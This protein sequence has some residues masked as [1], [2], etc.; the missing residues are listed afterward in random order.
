MLIYFCL[1]AEQGRAVCYWQIMYVIDLRKTTSQLCSMHLCRCF[2]SLCCSADENLMFFSVEL[3]SHT[4]FL[5]A[6][7]GND[8]WLLLLKFVFIIDFFLFRLPRLFPY[9]SSIGTFPFSRIWLWICNAH[10]KAAMNLRKSLKLKP[11]S[12]RINPLL[13]GSSLSQRLTSRLKYSALPIWWK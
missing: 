2:Y 11:R 7:A 10:I 5:N 8:A 9:L 13:H 1:E 12:I 3:N 6:V 4:L